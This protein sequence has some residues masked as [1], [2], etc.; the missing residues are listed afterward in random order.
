MVIVDD[1]MRFYHILLSKN[2][3]FILWFIDCIV[4][5]N[6]CLCYF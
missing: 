5:I 4:E 6:I 2:I 1:F 3:F